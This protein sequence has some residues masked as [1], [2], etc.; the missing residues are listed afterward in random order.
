VARIHA[1]AVAHYVDE[2]DFSGVQ[3]NAEVLVE[4]GIADATA[5]ADTDMTYLQGKGSFAFN[6]Q[7]FF[8][9]TSG[10][11]AEMF[12]DLTATQR[13]VGVYEDNVGGAKGYEGQ[14]NVSRQA[15]ASEKGSAIVLNVD[16]LGDAVIHR[17]VLLDVDTAVGATANG[18]EREHGASGA[19]ETLRGVL[20]LLAAPGGAGNNTLDVTI[21]SDTTGF[22][23]ATTRLTFAQLSQASSAS[24]EVVTS[25]TTV[26]DTFWRQVYTYAGAGSRTFSLV[27]A[28][29]IY[30]T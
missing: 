3:N 29:G 20:R 24:F 19:D 28:F 7:G 5:F 11:D 1:K 10:Y 16:W 17:A 13:S 2:F 27:T 9:G 4:T 26:T 14:T 30:L 23:S 25:R 6:F 8:D 12:I 15:R 21:E 22:P 18:T